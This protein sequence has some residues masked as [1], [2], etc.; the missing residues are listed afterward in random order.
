MIPE[1]YKHLTP[2]VFARI[3]PLT[4]DPETTDQDQLSARRYLADQGISL[5]T[6]IGARI[7]CLTHRC[8]GKEE[9]GKKSVGTIYH[10]IAYLNFLLNENGQAN[11]RLISSSLKSRNSIVYRLQQLLE[12]RPSF[13]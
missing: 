4:D 6:A 3:K 10:C 7:G 8:F 5:A 1:D 2:E 12:P 11:L 9:D 13:L